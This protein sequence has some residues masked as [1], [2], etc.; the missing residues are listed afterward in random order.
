MPVTQRHG[1]FSF[2]AASFAE[3]RV[4]PRRAASRGP[5]RLATDVRGR[6]TLESPHRRCER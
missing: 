6:R 2:S 5:V 1:H 3:E 4:T